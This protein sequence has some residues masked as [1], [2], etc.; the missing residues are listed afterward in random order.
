M[1]ER[2]TVLPEIAAL[3]RGEPTNSS[4]RTDNS[5]ALDV[6]RYHGVTPLLDARF[7][8]EAAAGWPASFRKACHEDA[9][10][11]AAGE[12]VGERY[13]LEALSALAGQRVP[14]LVLKGTALAYSHYP[15]PMLRPRVDCDL[16]V[17]PSNRDA[18]ARVLEAL[19]YARVSGPAGTYVGYQTALVRTRSSRPVHTIDLHWRI[20]DC[21]SFAW[22]FTFEELLGESVALPTLGPD[23]RRTGDA[24]SLL[25]ALLHRAGNNLY[26]GQGFGDRLIWLYDFHLLIDAMSAAELARFVQLATDKKVAAI[27]MD[28][29][30]RCAAFFPSHRL[31][32][33][34]AALE[35]SPDAAS[36]AKLLRAGRIGRE[37]LELRAIPTNS[38]RI[39]YLAARVCPRSEHLRERFPKARDH[40]LLALHAHR[41]LEGLGLARSRS[42]P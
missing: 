14:S 3:L 13:L 21:Q 18:A 33:A 15:S 5:S 31:D 2:G 6:A 25:L 1:I 35:R 42:E 29:L 27:A 28:G 8:A 36:G 34:I 10:L 41:W 22:L 40:G 26:E 38:A 30:R 39:A 16:L 4:R 37:W 32:E 7:A 20:S 11:H 12:L 24:H 9:L 23:A 19:G 17:A